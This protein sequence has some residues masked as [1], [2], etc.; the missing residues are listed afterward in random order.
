MHL[1]KL[2]REYGGKPAVIMAGSG[3]ILSYAE[4]DRQSNRIAQLF[5]ARGLRPGDHIAVLMENNAQDAATRARP[6]DGPAWTRARRRPGSAAA[7]VRPPSC[8]PGQS[9]WRT[10]E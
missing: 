9:Y 5:R 1:S 4:L 7:G 3:A 6:P 2:A 8:S 10:W